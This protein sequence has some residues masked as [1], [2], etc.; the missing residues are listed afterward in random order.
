MI[1]TAAHFKNSLQLHSLCFIS[2]CSSILLRPFPSPS[3]KKMDDRVKWIFWRK[4]FYFTGFTIL[5]VENYHFCSS[6]LQKCL[7]GNFGVGYTV[8]LRDSAECVVLSCTFPFYNCTKPHSYMYSFITLFKLQLVLAC[9]D[10]RTTN[11]KSCM[12][13]QWAVLCV[14]HYGPDP[15][16]P[17]GLWPCDPTR[18]IWWE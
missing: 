1:R 5:W 14:P 13:T 15:T 16:Q 10:I 2:L 8:Y 12:A 11:H 17:G 7:N 4:W 3:L 9:Q 18:S 6:K